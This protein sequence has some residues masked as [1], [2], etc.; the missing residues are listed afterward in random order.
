MNITVSNPWAPSSPRLRL[1]DSPLPTA[2][3][4][5]LPGHPAPAW[6]PGWLPRSGGVGGGSLMILSPDGITPGPCL[7]LQGPLPSGEG[8]QPAWAG[9]G[10]HILPGQHQV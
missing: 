1:G 4:P 6:S 7:G 9:G 5:S 10:G 8:T 3:V 2:C